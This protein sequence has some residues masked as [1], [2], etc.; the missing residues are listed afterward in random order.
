MDIKYLK[1][2]IKANK[3]E[4]ILQTKSKENDKYQNEAT[5]FKYLLTMISF[6]LLLPF[7]LFSF[8]SFDRHLPFSSV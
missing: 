3:G 8:A 1:D 4:A 6:L 7:K 5:P 2:N